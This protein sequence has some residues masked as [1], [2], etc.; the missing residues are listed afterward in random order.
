[1]K[2]CRLLIKGQVQ[3]VG[4][5][6]TVYR[7]AKQLNLT[8]WVQNTSLGVLVE[9]QGKNTASFLSLI[10]ENLPLLARIDSVEINDKNTVP[11]EQQF[12]IL[13]S[14]GGAAE[15]IISPDTAI[16]LEC[17]KEL[18]D[19]VSR[20]YHFPFINCTQCGPRFTITRSLPYD[21]CHTSM[22]A[23]ALCSDCRLE[24]NDP[25]NRRY[26]AQPTAC[27]QCGPQLSSD[28]QTIAQALINGKILALKGM[29]G[30]QLI[31]D[32]RNE[33]AVQKLRERKQREGKPLALM[34]L[35]TVSAES[36]VHM[37]TEEKQLLESSSRPIVL[38]KKGRE[39]LPELIAHGLCEFGIILPSTP[40]HY[41]IFHALAEYPK[42][43]DWLNHPDNSVLVVTS[44]NV[45]G[46]PLLI[47]DEKALCELNG[48]ADLIVSY[49]RQIVTRADDS[50]LRV[51]GG[52]PLFIRRARGYCPQPLQLPHA[53]PSVLAF[54][55]HLKNTFCITR[56]N[57]A[58]V[59]QYLGSLNNRETIDFFHESLEHWQRFLDVNI[60]A[61][62]CD[63]H[64]DFYTSRL[65]EQYGLPLMKVQ[66]HHAHL[67]AVAI[68]HHYTEP[69]IGLALDG[70]G[71]GNDGSAWGGELMLLEKETFE[72]LG[73]FAPLPLPGGDYAAR[74]PWRMGAAVLHCLGK[75]E[76]I[77]HYFA[78]QE[79]AIPVMR[80]L[81]DN[82]DYPQTTS[83]GRWFD[84]ASA[85]S[86]V[87]LRSNYEGQA[88]MLLESLVTDA[89]IINN[90]WSFNEKHFNPLPVFEHLLSTS[91]A[92]GANLFHGSLIA[93]LCEWIIYW[94]KKT[95]IRTV[96]LNGGCFL[97][98]VL[99][100]GLFNRLSRQGLSVYIPRQVP[101][102]D[103]G[104][105]LGQAWLAG[106]TLTS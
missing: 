61:I 90:S 35:N 28:I 37:N 53:I 85:L 69:A 11:T 101:P 50:V 97:N 29:G 52:A 84:A 32:A 27:T 60:E 26:H 38:L 56:G 34:L 80:M 2:R 95:G 94:S 93:G 41:L 51:V 46:N 73:S 15:T 14:E 43:C 23:F 30:Y 79:H 40:L 100:E 82:F 6:P 64:P 10:Y 5:R 58:F 59:S 70:Y 87:C 71:Y 66:H 8:G 96:L 89:E 25:A 91:A 17:L 68:E 36:F 7:I 102:N 21:R 65:A 74:E 18:F 44:A 81:L 13:K 20:Y 92:R 47:D 1:M 86:G 48:I 62:A 12:N 57:Q 78:E 31:C 24:Y 4:F 83:C 49:D 16:C 67:A 76:Y 75:T 72:H 45:S 63:L 106:K 55:A 42:G 54:G 19:P 22:D 88:A 105:S 9:I 103:S 104:L 39:K 98:K 33:K 99:T 3:G 77:P